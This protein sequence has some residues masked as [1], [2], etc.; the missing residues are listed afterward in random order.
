MTTSANVQPTYIVAIV[1]QVT[2]EVMI[3]VTRQP[4]GAVAEFVLTDNDF[5]G[6]T[7]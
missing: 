3:T 2:G 7:S 4:D 1:P 5:G 6:P